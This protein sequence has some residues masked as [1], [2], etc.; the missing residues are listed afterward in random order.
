MTPEGRPGVAAVQWW[1]HTSLLFG[2]K[3]SVGCAVI[4]RQSVKGVIAWSP[5]RLTMRNFF[6]EG[7]FSKFTVPGTINSVNT[8]E[9]KEKKLSEDCFTCNFEARAPS[10]IQHCCQTQQM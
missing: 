6:T 5:Q 4:L 2:L 8:L 7:T 1:P 9:T 3:E 10:A